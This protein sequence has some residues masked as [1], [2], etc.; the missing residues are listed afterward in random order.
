MK[1]SKRVLF[2]L[3]ILFFSFIYIG[4]T[5]DNI[6]AG[7]IL[8]YSGKLKFEKEVDLNKTVKMKFS[9]RDI[10]DN[11]EWERVRFTT[12]NNG[13]YTVKL[14][15][16]NPVNDKFYDGNYYICV[17]VEKDNK[18]LLVD[19]KPISAKHPQIDAES[20][21]LQLQYKRI[22]YESIRKIS[23]K[24][25]QIIN[26]RKQDKDIQHNRHR[27]IFSKSTFNPKPIIIGKNKI[28]AYIIE[29]S[30]VGYIIL[31]ADYNISPIIAFSRDCNFDFNNDSFLMKLIKRDLKI[32]KQEFNNLSQDIKIKNQW[33]YLLNNNIQ[34][35]DVSSQD[36]T[37][38]PF[39]TTRWHQRFPYNKYC[40]MDNTGQAAVGC[41]PI[42]LSQILYYWKY[43]RQIIFNNDIKY[44][45]KI[46][47][48]V[49][50][51]TLDNY[52]RYDL[53]T[54]LTSIDYNE[55][56]EN[57]IAALCFAAGLKTNT[58]YSSGGSTSS[59][60]NIFNALKSFGYDK[61]MEF[62]QFSSSESEINDVLKRIRLNMYSKIPVSLLLKNSDTNSGHFVVVD[63]Y[64]TVSNQE[65]LHINV[66]WADTTKTAWYSFSNNINE[67]RY[68]MKY[69]I[70]DIVG[71]RYTVLYPN[72]GDEL[73][74]GQTI[75]IRWLD[76]GN[77]SKYASIYLI[78]K[79][80]QKY[81][82]I[83]IKVN[84]N[85]VYTWN[86]KLPDNTD[87]GSKYFILVKDYYDN[88]AYDMSDN[89]FVIVNTA[90]PYGKIK[91]CDNK[92]VDK[93]LAISWNGDGYC[94]DGQWGIN[95]LCSEFSYDGG[96]CY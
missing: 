31:S 94:D 73:T 83:G 69:G 54:L 74:A 68:V 70:I 47:G 59:I 34:L 8:E 92:C 53:N 89:S 93:N 57:D 19:K 35:I 45:I 16:I 72:G 78:S 38:G 55:D 90:C 6:I 48:K 21:A 77:P 10:N 81:Y 4:I 23:N 51:K 56:N 40:P 95:L 87:S 28:L 46:D 91:D 18:F 7:R 13:E 64:E 61:Q 63:G 67:L 62:V 39:L 14:G 30:P 27:K 50:E 20:E 41:G 11:I 79:E 82:R 43:P 42:A 76:E 37:Y 15:L 65:F 5:A 17:S 1:F 26:M 2:I 32:R 86:V 71:K 12:L 66:G 84:N 3:I 80:N 52:A 60:G 85:G 58:E 25:I 24:I 22:D 36:E 75:S 9:I 96:D 44:F 33:D 29:T 88:K 49:E